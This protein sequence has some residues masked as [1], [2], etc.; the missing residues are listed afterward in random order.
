MAPSGSDIINLAVQFHG[1]IV[2]TRIREGE[3]LKNSRGSA[4]IMTSSLS[5]DRLAGKKL[6]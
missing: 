2:T 5:H 4:S 1:R 3:S 6:D